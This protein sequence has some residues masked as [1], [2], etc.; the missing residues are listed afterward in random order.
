MLSNIGEKM[1][2]ATFNINSVNAHM[3]C[4]TEFLKQQ[5]P[6]VVFLQEIKTEFD[7]FPF[8]DLKMMGY[9]AKVLGQ[10]S[11]NGVA[12]LSKHKMTVNTE[13]L[14]EFD[15][16]NARYI[17]ANV[18]IENRSYC[19]ASVYLPNG[20]PPYNDPNDEKKF[21]Y[22]LNFM[23]SL[24]THCKKL[25][26][27]HDNLIIGGDMNVIFTDFDVYNPELFRNNALFREEVKQRF[28]AL[29]HLGL[30]DAFRCKNITD[31]G[32]TYWDYGGGAFENDLGMRIDYFLLSP[33][34]MDKI[35]N[36]TVIKNIRAMPKTS[37]HAPLL[38]EFEDSL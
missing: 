12:I 37:D 14:P 7:N 21:I 3:E 38:A 15:D 23:D 18:V 10:K 11:Y 13:N 30:Y 19:L 2:I 16:D 5:N 17:E 9:E 27:E 8:F 20:N 25:L 34:M 35:K 28:A 33:L 26:M 22:K 4:L 1:K 32:Y 36:C 29:K 6:D 24:Y 31:N